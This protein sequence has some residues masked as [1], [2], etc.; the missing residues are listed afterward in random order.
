MKVVNFSNLLERG[1]YNYEIGLKIK[2]I[3]NFKRNIRGLNIDV[4]TA[5]TTMLTERLLL[6]YFG[7]KRGRALK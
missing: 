5:S 1:K 4:V 7:S 2:E 6:T 3:N